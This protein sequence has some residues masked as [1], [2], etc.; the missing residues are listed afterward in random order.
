M[1]TE[2]CFTLPLSY[3]DTAGP[4]S[5]APFCLDCAI[6]NTTCADTGGKEL[7]QEVEEKAWRQQYLTFSHVATPDIY[8]HVEQAITWA[9]FQTLRPPRHARRSVRLSFLVL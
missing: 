9:S 4:T 2:G 5:V 6:T 1:W 3:P 7:A 8:D